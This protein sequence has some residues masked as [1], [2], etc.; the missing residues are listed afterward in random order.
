MA[1]QAPPPSSKGSFKQGQLTLWLS[2][3]FVGLVIM[4]LPTVVLIFFGMLPTVVSAIIDRTPKRNATFCIGGI[5]L[6]GV[7]PYMMD[8]WL[9]NN[10]ME[11]AMWILTDVFSLAVMYGAASFGWMIFQSLPPVVATFITVIAQ[12]KVSSLRSTQ[13]K[14]VE[15]WGEDVGTPQDIIDMREQFGDAALETDPGAAPVST[16]NT[17]TDALL[18]GI[19]N[20]LGGSGEQN[21]APP[22]V[23]PG[24]V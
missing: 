11:G 19:D 17:D 1:K 9:G 20:L 4:S 7:S 10:S 3:G 15:E 12:S 16:G 14:L 22:P 5:N 8:L 6:C 23:S 18:D 2:I 13:K 24:T 21:G